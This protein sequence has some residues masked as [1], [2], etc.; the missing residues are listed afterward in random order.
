MEFLR[1]NFS[2]LALGALA[3]LCVGIWAEVFGETPPGVLTVAVMDVGQGDS[4]FIESPTGA[5]IVI[6]GGPDD[7]LLHELPKLMPLADRS[8]DAVMETHPDAD[9]IT[10]FIDLLKRYV[11]GDFIEPGIPK[12]TLTAETLEKEIDTEHIPRVLARRGMWLDLGGG[13][14]LDILWPDFDASTLK[15]DDANE[16]CIVAHL[17]YGNTSM[18]FMCDAP[19]DVENSLMAFGST[20]QLKSDI[21][22]VGHHG[23]AGSTGSDFVGEVDP[24]IAIISLGANNR[25]GFPKQVTLDTLAAHNVQVLRTDEEGTVEFVSDGTTFVRK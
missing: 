22:K 11:V 1:R 7:S 18:I 10:G 20:T 14:R 4:I 5:Q 21:L 15:P 16:G 17:V 24:R 2:Y 12:P 19:M 6:D 13:A 23:S 25:Y 8:L 9:H 3:V